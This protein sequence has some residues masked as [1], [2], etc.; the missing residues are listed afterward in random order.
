M[1]TQYNLNNHDNN[2]IKS[3]ATVKLTD[4][5]HRMNKEKKKRTKN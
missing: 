1:S 2:E 3:R 5:L 4:L